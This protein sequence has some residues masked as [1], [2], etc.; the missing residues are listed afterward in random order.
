M[1]VF[2]SPEENSGLPMLYVQRIG[3]ASVT[4]LPGTEGASYPFWSPDGAN[5]GFFA[6][7]KMQKMAVIRRHAASAGERPGRTR[8][9]LGKPRM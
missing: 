6:N 1:L 3:S 4:L 5:I 7:G 8:R 2:V 9:Q